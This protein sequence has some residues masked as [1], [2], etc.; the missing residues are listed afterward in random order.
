MNDAFAGYHPLVNFVWF[1]A[2]L[3]YTMLF[4]HPVMLAV[5]LVWRRGVQPVPDGTAGSPGAG[6][7]YSAADAADGGAQPSV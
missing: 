5:A 4:M 2:V 3:T 7:G 6:S 1:A